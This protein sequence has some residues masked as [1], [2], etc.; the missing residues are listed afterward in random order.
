MAKVVKSRGSAALAE[1]SLSKAYGR[2]VDEHN[3][4]RFSFAVRNDDLMTPA[5]GHGTYFTL[6]TSEAEAE[7][8]AVYIAQV[9]TRTADEIGIYVRLPGPA[10]LRALADKIEARKAND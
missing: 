6:T 7:G 1:G 2:P 3:E 4:A 10:A 5:K 8:M 9:L